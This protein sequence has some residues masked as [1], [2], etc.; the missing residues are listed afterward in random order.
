MGL[1]DLFRKKSEEIPGV[2]VSKF[3]C[4]RDLSVLNMPAIASV[5][6]V[7]EYTAMLIITIS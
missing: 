7:N 2:T 5:T 6:F 4:V 1:F 3:E